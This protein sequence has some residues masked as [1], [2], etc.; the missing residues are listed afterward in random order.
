MS[1][2]KREVLAQGRTAEMLAWKDGWALKLFFDWFPDDGVS[3]EAR[4]AR[5]V[6][7]AGLPV[8]AVGEIVELDGRLGLPYERLF[9]RSMLEELDGE[10][11]TLSRN[12]RILAELQ[13]KIHSS[14]SQPGVPGQR[15][16]LKRK[17]HEAPGLSQG[18]VKRLIKALEQLPDGDRLCHGDMHPAN[19]ILTAGGP[20]VIDWIDATLGNPLADVARSQIILGGVGARVSQA[21]KALVDLVGRF[22]AIYEEYYFELRPGGAAE[23][24]AWRPVIAAARMNEG[25]EEQQEWLLAQVEAGLDQ[26]RP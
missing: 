11:E 5:A 22:L 12:A 4:L 2:Q 1:R 23:C 9:G 3:H 10:P 8:P 6:H 25:I 18:Q 26:K 15:E 13:T 21:N 17:I 24:E 14:G 7:A 20:V 16:K 19:V